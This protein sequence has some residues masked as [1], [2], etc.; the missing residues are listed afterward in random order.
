[1]AAKAYVVAEKGAPFEL[2]DVVLDTPQSNEILVEIKYT[3][4]CH[5]VCHLH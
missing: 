3:G 5:T 4:L 1:M 2:T